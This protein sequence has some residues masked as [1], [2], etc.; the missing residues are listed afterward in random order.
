M[1]R[2]ARAGSRASR[3]AAPSWPRSGAG[4]G[5][6][7][8]LTLTLTLALTLTLTLAPALTLTLALAL[9]LTQVTP[10]APA[11]RADGS[12]LAALSRRLMNLTLYEDQAPSP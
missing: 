8:T 9:P 5:L 11:A 2:A 6:G 3:A 7:R 10:A 1:T 12:E 4:L